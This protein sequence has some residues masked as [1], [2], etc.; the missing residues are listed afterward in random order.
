MQTENIT[1]KV[2]VDVARLFRSATPEQRIKA[3]EEVSRAIRYLLLSSQEA[4]QEFNRISEEMGTYA[5]AQG[6]TEERLEELLKE[7]DE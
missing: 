7:D 6:L 5:K 4:A 1:L 2:P 3:G